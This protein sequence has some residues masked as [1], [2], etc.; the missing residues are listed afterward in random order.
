MLILQSPQKLLTVLFLLSSICYPRLWCVEFVEATQTSPPPNW[1]PGTLAMTSH[2]PSPHAYSPT[3][4]LHSGTTGQFGHDEVFWVNVM[5]LYLSQYCV[6]YEKEEVSSHCCKKKA[7]RKKYSRIKRIL[8]LISRMFLFGLR[9]AFEGN[10]ALQPWHVL[11]L[12]TTSV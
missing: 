11:S 7:G 2:P 5:W 8:F 9:P 6:L 4:M 1:R 3:S 12:T 10:I